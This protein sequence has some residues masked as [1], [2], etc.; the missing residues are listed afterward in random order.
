[1]RWLLVAQDGWGLGHV[2]RQLG[3]ARELQR[4]K[5]HD[6]IL[7]L[8]YSEATN[9]IAAEG[10]PSVKLPASQWFKPSDQR[11]IDD[12]RRFWLISATVNALVGSYQPHAIVIDTFPVGPLGELAQLLRLPC[13]R[14][15]IAREVRKPLKQWEYRSSLSRFNA[16]IAPYDENEIAI[17]CPQETNLHWVGP[18][19]VR[20]RKDLLSRSE[21]R[22]R[23]GLPPT[24][25]I[26]LV[27]FGG[28]GNPVYSRL[29]KW[30][31]EL[32]DSH[33]DWHF[34]LSRPP[35]LQQ[36]DAGLGKPNAQRFAYYPMAECYAAFDM[37]IS[38]TGSSAYE[39]AYLGVPAI[40][41]PDVSPQHDEDHVA[42]A[43][44]VLGE[45]G[46]FVVPAFDGPALHAAFSAMSNKERL[47]AMKEDRASL[48]LQN[49]AENCA[50][51]LARYTKNAG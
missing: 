22:Q 21:A 4:L 12:F 3:L 16:L 43:K 38:A 13:F 42:K 10:F 32:V 15:L 50:K 11:Y 46:G 48:K 25:R 17:D 27:S 5:P 44:R 49:G 1:M 37:A 45:N 34:A 14:F 24:G 36:A 40:L 41:I 28:G 33:P 18:I 26:C 9:L 35:L 2:S 6:E 51:L 7:F 39:L 8:T 29:E 47:Q 31:L 19:L 30:I 20:G 23:L